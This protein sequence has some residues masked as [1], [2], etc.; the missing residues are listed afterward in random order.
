MKLFT[1]EIRPEGEASFKRHDQKEEEVPEVD[2]TIILSPEH[3]QTVVRKLVLHVDGK[4]TNQITIFT[5]KT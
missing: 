1:V 5:K 3:V 2:E 4:P